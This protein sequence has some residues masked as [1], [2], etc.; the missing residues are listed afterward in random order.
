MVEESLSIFTE[1]GDP[2]SRGR[3]LIAQ[4]QGRH[5]D[6]REQFEQV[7]HIARATELDP[8]VLE[9]QYRLA[10]LM[11]V[12][13]PAAALAFLDQIIA[14]PAAEHMTRERAIHLREALLAGER[15]PSPAHHQA[16]GTRVATTGETLTPREMDVLRL[17]AHGRSKHTIASEL[18]VAVGTVKRHVNSIFGKLEAETRLEA[19]TR[20]R[21]L[22]LV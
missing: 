1:L 8:L 19:A 10:S 3:A 15:T 2:W 13:T 16:P 7:L 6:A 20:A 5:E 22:G 9:A 17:L 11:A 21:D 12:D 4:V 18:I 14:H